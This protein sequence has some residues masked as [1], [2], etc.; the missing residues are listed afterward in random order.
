MQRLTIALAVLVWSASAQAEEIQGLVRVVGSSLNQQVL[1]AESGK[2]DGPAL[3]RGDVGKR[4]G[5]LTGLVVKV[6]G[7]WH[8]NKKGEKSCVEP[9]DFQVLKLPNGRDP[10]VGTLSEKSG[11]YEV[12]SEDGKTRSLADVPDGLKKLSGKKVILDLR[13]IESPAAKDVP[14]KV[15]SY[16]EHP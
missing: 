8:L 1:L 13:T 15:V 5:R 9:K 14:A 7:D 2:S 12:A 4:I 3:C 10:V 11:V 6:T 16:S